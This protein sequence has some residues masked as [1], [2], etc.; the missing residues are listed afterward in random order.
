MVNSI[1]EF[2]EPL[3]RTLCWGAAWDMTRDGEVTAADYLALALAGVEQETEVGTV[4]SLLRL[5]SQAVDP[6][7]DP[8]QI[9]PRRVRLA[10]RAFEL[11][12]ASDAG[13]DLQLAFARAAAANATTDD[14]LDRIAD[15][16]A[17]RATIDGLPI[18]TDLRWTLLLR[19]V[20]AG[21]AE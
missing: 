10:N 3:A 20:A 14:Q 5:A 7:G 16:L 4:Q 6:F 9:Q 1:G 2:R 8:S 19:L 15:L 17:G 13:G 21:R 12:D 11:L 18:D